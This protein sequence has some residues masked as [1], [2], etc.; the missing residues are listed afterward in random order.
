MSLNRECLFFI[1]IEDDDVRV[2]ADGDR[3]FLRKQ[4]EHLRGRGGG[5]LDKAIQRDAVLND[6]VIDERDAMFDAGCAVRNLCEIV[7]AQFFLLLHAKWA[8][9]G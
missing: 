3:P 7:F 6:A 8:M 2:R 4:S 9:V 1:S 5:Q